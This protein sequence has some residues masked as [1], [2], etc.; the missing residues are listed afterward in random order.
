MITLKSFYVGTTADIDL[1]NIG[2]DVRSFIRET[3][4]DSGAVT[5]LSRLS[6]AALVVLPIEGKA[7]A[8]LR[9]SLKQEFAR[10]LPA[11]LRPLWPASLT[12][13]IEKGRFI[14]EP[15]QDLFLLDYEPS[16]KRREVVVQLASVEPEPQTGPQ[17]RGKR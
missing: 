2:H 10:S 15:W 6:G 4:L 8:D 17:Q 9:A 12:I 5:V 3:K 14:F 7:A 16:A 11:S 13:P 1:I